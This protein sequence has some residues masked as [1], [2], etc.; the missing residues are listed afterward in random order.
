MINNLNY[1]R[2][3]AILSVFGFHLGLPWF[4]H[5]Y[6]G[7]DLFLLLSGILIKKSLMR[8]ST[9]EFFEARFQRIYPQYIF[10]IFACSLLAIFFLDPSVAKSHYAHSIFATLLG[11]WIYAYKFTGYFDASAELLPLLHLW[12]ISVEIFCYLLSPIL[13][14]FSRGYFTYFILIFLVI[15]SFAFQNYYNPFPRIFLFILG[16]SFYSKSKISNWSFYTLGLGSF[17]VGIFASVFLD[18]DMVLGNWYFFIG[19]AVLLIFWNIPET[20]PNKVILYISTRSYEIYLI[21]WPLI[22]FEKNY[23]RNSSLSLSEVTIII[24]GTLIISEL[25]YFLQRSGI[26]RRRLVI[27]LTVFGALSA[28]IIFKDGALYRIS[29]TVEITTIDDQIDKRF[30]RHDNME[31]PILLS[32]DGIEKN[33]ILILGDSHARHYA[34]VF[35]KLGFGVTV[36]DLGKSF[37]K[38][39]VSLLN[40]YISEINFEHIFVA[41]LFSRMEKAE[42]EAFKAYVEKIKRYS[43]LVELPVYDFDP[44]SCYI[45]NNSSLLRRSCRFDLLEGVPVLNAENYLFNKE[46]EN[47]LGQWTNICG[48]VRVQDAFLNQNNDRFIVIMNNEFLYRDNNHMSELLSDSALEALSQRLKYNPISRR[49]ECKISSVM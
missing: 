22:V 21:H 9:R 38:V 46:F 3:I 15:A 6:Y 31:I 35:E 39:D 17:L 36:V 16:A 44:V 43:V 20:Q 23:F 5:G 1:L 24:V 42:L 13:F 2:C 10:V 7:V 8:K 19:W 48:F 30:F 33:K 29:S 25:L 28:G 32:A 4:A 47:E 49:T 11:S 45:S 14:R 12:T 18:F 40:N 27:L 37:R 26:I 34:Q 41:R